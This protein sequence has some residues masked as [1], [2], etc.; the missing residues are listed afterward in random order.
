MSRSVEY[1]GIEIRNH[2]QKLR[3]KRK[4]KRKECA[5]KIGVIKR[6]K[7]LRKAYVRTDRHCQRSA[8]GCG[9]RKSAE[10]LKPWYQHT[11]KCCEGKCPA[12]RERSPQSRPRSSWRS[13][14]WKVEHELAVWTGTWVGRNERSVEKACVG[15]KLVEESLR[16]SHKQSFVKWK[17]LVLRSQVGKFHEREMAE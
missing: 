13:T 5:Q 8:D 3:K 17:T 2:I 15:S 10:A 6:T 1:L 4:E 12:Q 11:E 9:A 16:T 7:E 14:I